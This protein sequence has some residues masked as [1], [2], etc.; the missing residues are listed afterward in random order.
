MEIYKENLNK[1]IHYLK[2]KKKLLIVSF[3]IILVPIL[4]LIITKFTPSSR[5]IRSINKLSKE[6]YS[7][8]S[9]LQ[10][11]ITDEGIDSE[12]VKNELPKYISN[13]ED[14]TEKLNKLEVP[15]TVT[16]IKEKFNETLKLNSSLYNE[17]LS[18]YMTPS[19]SNLSNKLK[20]YRKTLDDFNNIRNDLSNLRI[21]DIISNES[22][23]FF[24]KTYK[25]FDTLIQVNMM[26]DI[27]NEKK[28]E[29]ILKVDNIVVK[30]K[31]IDEDLKPALDNIKETN[32]NFDT[33]IN[34]VSNKKSIIDNIKNDFYM[35]SVPE[36]ANL[37]HS[38]LLETINL[39][40][41]YISS[42]DETLHLDIE[43]K[44]NKYKLEEDYKN[45]FSK[46]SD[47]ITSLSKLCNDLEYFKEK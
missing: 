29:Y 16:T 10:K 30:L 24:D 33:L 2:P 38:K 14:T 9:N 32:R 15:P 34:D 4:L 31:Q 45:T 22:L 13:L 17:C 46:Y 18:L 8:N 6:T 28:Y 36:E 20:K 3:L 39:Y 37:V 47:F 19:S 1:F 40:D 42:M 44:E 11:L 43:S 23:N 12:A 41:L 21:E 27:S 35:I 25:Y 7:I 5:S 26:K